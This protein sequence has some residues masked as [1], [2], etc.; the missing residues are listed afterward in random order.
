MAPA[1]KLGDLMG[2]G[3]SPQSPTTP[4]YIIRETSWR[5]RDKHAQDPCHPDKQP[6]LYTTAVF[7]SSSPGKGR[8]VKSPTGGKE[9]WG[10]RLLIAIQ[11]GLLPPHFGLPDT[12]M[13]ISPKRNHFIYFQ[14]TG[15]T[16]TSWAS[17]QGAIL[18]L[19]QKIF[20]KGTSHIVVATIL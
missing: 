18:H 19:G 13:S 5:G 16:G 7:R 6:S 9:A 8:K 1:V 17:L 4:L 15:S 10:C 3:E 11:T 20:G 12:F 2:A 14:G